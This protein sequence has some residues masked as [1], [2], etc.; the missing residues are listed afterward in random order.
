VS[1]DRDVAV[2]EDQDTEVL[3]AQRPP[4]P[5]ES[6]V[7]ERP[8][9]VMS[10]ETLASGSPASATPPPATTVWSRWESAAADLAI[11]LCPTSAIRVLEQ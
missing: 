10:V 2:L 7:G 3:P 11:K 6:G 4:R 5:S 8:A 1:R 9:A